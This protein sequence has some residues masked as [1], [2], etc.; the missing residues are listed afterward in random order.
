MAARNMRLMR[1]ARHWPQSE[2][3]KEELKHA[4]PPARRRRCRRGA[5][6]WGSPVFKANHVTEAVG[7]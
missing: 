6:G 1:G 2:S 3:R 5:S 4:L 7:R